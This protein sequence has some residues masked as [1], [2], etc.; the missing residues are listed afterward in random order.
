MFV[1]LFDLFAL[2][3]AVVAF[4]FARKALNQAAEL[5]ARLDA[6]EAIEAMTGQARPVTLPPQ[7]TR[8]PSSPSVAAEPPATAEADPIVPAVEKEIAAPS[9]GLVLIIDDEIAIQEA[10]RSLLTSWGYE[11]IVAGS[12]DEMMARLESCPH[13]PDLIISDYRLRDHENGVEV[14]QRLQSEY[15]SDIPGV[16]ITGDTAPAPLRAARE[17][18]F[19]LLH[20]PVASSKLR[21][22]IGNLTGANA[23]ASV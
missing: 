11:T 18:G 13:R 4:I 1:S 19:L 7:Q 3:I 9:R 8:A 20:K 12:G 5:R 16:L 14:I 10:M 22:A 17:S 6:I 2:V 23:P 15:N 21:A